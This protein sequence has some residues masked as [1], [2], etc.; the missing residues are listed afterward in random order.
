MPCLRLTGGLIPQ[1]PWVGLRPPDFI[2]RHL[3]SL[4]FCAPKIWPQFDY[5][6]RTHLNL[7]YTKADFEAGKWKLVKAY[8]SSC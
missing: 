2:L 6:F 7:L 1:T 5:I 4:V 3:Q 8:M